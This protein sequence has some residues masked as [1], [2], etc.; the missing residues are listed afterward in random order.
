VEIVSIVVRISLPDVNLP[1]FTLAS[2]FGGGDTRLR[3]LHLELINACSPPQSGNRDS[4]T[5]KCNH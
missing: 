5:I 2:L 1:V 3:H 4:E